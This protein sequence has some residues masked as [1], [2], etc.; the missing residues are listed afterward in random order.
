MA[1]EMKTRLVVTCLLMAGVMISGAG[2]AAEVAAFGSEIEID[3]PEGWSYSAHGSL[4]KLY[5]VRDSERGRLDSET[6]KQIVT[7]NVHLERRLSSEDAFQR[8]RNLGAQLGESRSF[9]L[10]SGWPSVAAQQRTT[11]PRAQKSAREIEVTLWTVAL[12]IDDKVV[13]VE[14]WVPLDADDVSRQQ[15]DE[16]LSSVRALETSAEPNGAQR[17]LDDLRRDPLKGVPRLSLPVD[18]G[19]TPPVI[20]EAVDPEP[21]GAIPAAGTTVRVTAQNGRDSELEIAVADGAQDIV[22]GS[23]NGFF[24]STDGGGTWANSVGIGSNDPSVTWAPSGGPRGTFYAANIASPSTGFWFSTDGGNNFTQGAPMYTCGQNGDP[25]C[26][27]AFPD[28]EHIAAD[29]FNVA[30]GGDQIYDVWRHL[31]GN[32]GIVCSADSG[33]NWSANGQF[34][35]G[36]LPKVSVGQDG[37]VYVAFHPSNDDDI[38]VHKFSSCE[39]GLAAQAGFPTTVVSDPGGVACPIPGVDRCNRRNSLASPTVA[40]DDLDP[41]HIY[42]AYAAN[43]NPGP[44]GWFQAC[45]NQNLCNELIV[46]QDSTDGGLTWSPGDPNRTVVVSSSIT[47][48]RYMPWACA[49]GGEMFVSWYDRR[50]ALPGG[51]TVSNNSLTDFFMGS[52]YRN[53]V[54]NL[55]RG[56]ERQLNEVDT[57]DAQCEAGFATGSAASWPSAVDRVGDSESCS[58]QPQLGGICCVAGEVDGN[59]FC[60]P[61][62]ASTQA[63]CDFNPDTCGGG[64]LCSIRR[65]SPKYGDYNGSACAEGRFFATWAS[66]TS[67]AAVVPA[68]ANIDTFFTS[69]VVCCVPEVRVPAALDFGSL[70]E[71]DVTSETFN[72]CNTGAENLVIGSITSDN[73]SF[74]VLEPVPSFP[75]TVSPDFCFP[76]EVEFDPSGGSQAG[77]LTIN[78][79]DPARPALDVPVEAEVGS[80]ELRVAIADSGNFGE[81]CTGLFSDLDLELL[82]QGTCPVRLDSLSVDDSRFELPSTLEFPIVLAAEAD[83]TIP[84]RFSP[85]ECGVAVEATLTLTSNDV[86]GP[87]LDN[88]F[89][90]AFES[91]DLARWGAPGSSGSTRGPTT[92]LLIPLEGIAPCPDLN[93]AMADS[94]DFGSVCAEDHADLD[95]TLFNQGRCDLTISSIELLPDPDSFELPESTSFPLV[96]SHDADFTFPVRFSPDVCTDAESMRTL[97]INS[98]DPDEAMLDLDVSG[99]APCGNLLV[100]P[101][102]LTG[103]NAFPPT[104]VDSTGTLGCFAESSIDLRN[105]GECPLTITDIGAAG[106]DFSVVSPPL[107]PVLLPPGEET[108]SVGVRFHPQSDADPLTPNEVTGQLT[109]S[110][111]DPDAAG[112]ADLCGESAAQSGV[113]ILVTDVSTGTPIPIGEV[114]DIRIDSFGINTPGPVHLRFRDQPV[115]STM[116]CG[117]EIQYH[118]N[119]ETLPS[120]ETTGNNPNSSY[121]AKAKEGNLQTTQTF[122]LGQCE[123]RLDQLQL[124]GN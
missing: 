39:N 30:V 116:V 27:A 75:V 12:A 101:A 107:F 114:D 59:G 5:S 93:V 15:L 98:D 65:G 58:L 14:A 106:A 85:D 34:F 76:F 67:P 108:L 46:A 66:A 104:V 54:G 25:A 55:T 33:A 97:R 62:A 95:L 52:A 1:S 115:Q 83:T 60:T 29:R 53:V 92:D 47:A 8:L 9:R 68:T 103:L 91:G 96:L 82:N 3:V 102:G 35:A 13:H 16:I 80:G 28:Q 7:V 99:S 124:S 112:V 21:N 77:L 18:S 48:R 10:T 20:P 63:R 57:T 88:L 89:E 117:N 110:S 61:T 32:W 44:G 56:T 51:T 121:D 86:S 36:D 4:I 71:E 109:V 84:L 37:F 26:A 81:V 113:R 64:E 19:E 42:V 38:L 41:N 40:V 78:T 90:D 72:V 74:S 118:V 22:I 122:T 6:I 73:P 24:F 111:D 70:C 94:G 49:A 11:W 100:D 23:N 43:T 17:A 79:N 50:A 105:N 31:D 45:N 119:Q 123:V 120:T 87:L 2:M 69:D